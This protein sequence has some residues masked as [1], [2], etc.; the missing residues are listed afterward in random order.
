MVSPLGG[1]S[2]GSEVARSEPE[3]LAKQSRR[4]YRVLEA[5]TEGDVS[6]MVFATALANEQVAGALRADLAYIIGRGHTLGG[7]HTAEM[8]PRT[9]EL[10]SDQLRVQA[11]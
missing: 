6:N 2:A 11:V 9:V 8:G 4:V 1:V 10:P 5:A 3:A 7:K